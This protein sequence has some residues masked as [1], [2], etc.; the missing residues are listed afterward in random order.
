LFWKAISA[1]GAGRVKTTW[2]YGT[3]SS[4]VCRAATQAARA[5]P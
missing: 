5:D 3:G 1:A 4:S 2:K